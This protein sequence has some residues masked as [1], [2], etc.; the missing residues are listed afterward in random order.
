M[1][2]DLG[3]VVLAEAGLS[4]IGLGVRPPTADLGQMIFA[5]VDFITT[6]PWVA[7]FPGLFLTL[8]VLGFNMMGDAMRDM[9]DPR[10]RR[11]F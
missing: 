9:F 8:M 10:L 11:Q 3:A 1:S 5:A 4:F 7:L 2:I 6:A